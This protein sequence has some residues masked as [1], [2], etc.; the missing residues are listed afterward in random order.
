MG[1]NVH[2]FIFHCAIS[3]I[4]LLRTISFP[5]NHIQKERERLSGLV[6]DF[7]NEKTELSAGKIICKVKESGTKQS[8]T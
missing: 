5:E 8:S 4:M 2:Q 7:R 3:E 6:Y 1:P